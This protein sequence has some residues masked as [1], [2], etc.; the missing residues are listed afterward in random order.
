MPP[1]N[2]AY[3]CDYRYPEGEVV[4]WHEYVDLWS[5]VLRVSFQDYWRGVAD[6]QHLKDPALPAH[7]SRHDARKY[8]A[9]L[10]A[11][12]WLLS[13]ARDPRAFCWILHILKL[14]P[15]E[16]RTRMDKPPV[17]DNQPEETEEE[18]PQ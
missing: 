18:N 17:M 1:T 12:D 8:R 3:L 2:L 4:Y 11:R 15:A 5:A 9:W 13:D 7:T 6:G 16:I 10:D 14:D